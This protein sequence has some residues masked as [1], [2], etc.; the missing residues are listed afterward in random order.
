MLC[1]IFLK[2]KK[3]TGML[4]TAAR[5]YNGSIPLMFYWTAHSYQPLKYHWPWND[6][7]FPRSTRP[8]VIPLNCKAVIISLITV[9]LEYFPQPKFTLQ[10]IKKSFPLEHHFR[11]KRITSG[12]VSTKGKQFSVHLV[13]F[14]K[15]SK[16]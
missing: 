9:S 14:L 11:Y 8:T 5:H 15:E 16:G 12:V 13:I 1:R 10:K 7:H 4:I 3:R 2:G 6:H